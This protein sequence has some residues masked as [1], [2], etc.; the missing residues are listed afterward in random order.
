MNSWIVSASHLYV[1]SHDLAAHAGLL[2]IMQWMNLHESEARRLL[3]ILLVSQEIAH[4]KLRK[5]IMLSGMPI[6]SVGTNDFNALGRRSL[7]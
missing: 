6:P 4:K 2:L 5:I 1:F 3:V 7:R